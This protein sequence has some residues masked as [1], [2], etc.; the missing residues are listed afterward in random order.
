MKCAYMRL[1]DFVEVPFEFGDVWLRESDA[2]V[3]DM[4]RWCRLGL[5]PPSW[6]QNALLDLM[7]AVLGGESDRRG[8]EKERNPGR[9]RRHG[10]ARQED[11]VW[12]VGC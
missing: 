10:W 4:V 3:D 7:R 8:G 5:G 2:E 9:E 11:V 1:P 12:G 6:R